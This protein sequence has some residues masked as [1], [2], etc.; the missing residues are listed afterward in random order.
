[1]YRLSESSVAPVTD[2]IAANRDSPLGERLL[3][4]LGEFVEH[5]DRT[6]SLPV[7]AVARLHAYLVPGTDVVVAAIVDR[8]RRLIDLVAVETLQDGSRA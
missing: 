6:P 5:P 2:W 3:A 1:V 4:W 8:A 7:R